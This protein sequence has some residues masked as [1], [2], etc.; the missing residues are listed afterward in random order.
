MQFKTLEEEYSPDQWARLSHG[1]RKLRDQIAGKN[2]VEISAALYAANCRATKGAP[3]NI[4][5]IATMGRLLRI[6]VASLEGES[7][8]SR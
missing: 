4:Q 6:P 2:A 7:V 1:M 5:A 8:I 3:F